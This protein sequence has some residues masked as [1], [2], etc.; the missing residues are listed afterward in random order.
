VI[1]YASSTPLE[2]G[3]GHPNSAYY[4]YAGYAVISGISEY[5]LLISLVKFLSQG[6]RREDQDNLKLHRFNYM[7]LFG[8]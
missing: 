3:K 4:W 6:E 2:C 7:K 5:L 1:I 8:G